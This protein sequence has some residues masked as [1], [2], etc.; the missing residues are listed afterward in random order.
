MA[1]TITPVRSRPA[2]VE[3]EDRGRVLAQRLLHMQRTTFS[4][5]RW[6]SSGVSRV[7]RTLK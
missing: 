3:V 5:C 2:A 1:A 6:F 7:V 4:I